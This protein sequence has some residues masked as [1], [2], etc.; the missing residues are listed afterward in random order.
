[1][2]AMMDVISYAY[3]IWDFLGSDAGKAILAALFMLS[4]ALG[5][6]PQV[7]ANSVFQA[8]AN[9][10][11]KLSGKAVVLLLVS[12]SVA[13]CSSYFH[14]KKCLEPVNGYQACHHVHEYWTEAAC[15][16]SCQAK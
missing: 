6:V 16:G 11:K 5:M 3:L 15:A 12:L 9:A 14:A 1:M 10:L 8:V 13:S 4:E 2:G 7:R